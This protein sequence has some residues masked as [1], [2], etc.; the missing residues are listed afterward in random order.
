M[1]FLW[2]LG[3]LLLVIQSASV[4]ALIQGKLRLGWTLSIVLGQLT[5]WLLKLLFSELLSLFGAFKAI[6]LV[7]LDF[8]LAVIFVLLAARVINSLS[9]P[10]IPKLS[11]FD[12]VILAALI[13]SI[14]IQLLNV[15]LLAQVNW[16]SHTYHLP[17][18]AMW[19]QQGSLE[20]FPTPNGRE[21]VSQ[22]LPSVLYAFSL[23]YSPLGVA[24]AINSFISLLL[25]VLAV[26]SLVLAITGSQSSALFATLFVAS[27]PMV[28]VQAATTQTDLLASSSIALLIAVMAKV[29]T[30]KKRLLDFTSQL[31]IGVSVAFAIAAKATAV[32]ALVPLLI[33]IPLFLKLEKIPKTVLGGAGLA[34]AITLLTSGPYFFR[35][36]SS[37]ELSEAGTQVLSTDYSLNSILSGIAKNGATAL[38]APNENWTGTVFDA[39]TSLS[40]LLNLDLNA[41]GTNFMPTIPFELVPASSDSDMGFP[42]HILLAG[43]LLM[44]G[45]FRFNGN[46]SALLL[47]FGG[48][49][50]LLLLSITIKW[51]PWIGRF[52]FQSSYLMAAGLA[53]ISTVPKT[54]LRLSAVGLASVLVIASAWPPHRSIFPSP[55][56]SITNAS[57]SWND[58]S[59]AK[60]LVLQMGAQGFEEQIISIRR[61]LETIDLENYDQVFLETNL[62]SPKFFVS[63]LLSESGFKG[64]VTNVEIETEPLNPGTLIINLLPCPNQNEEVEKTGNS[65]YPNGSLKIFACRAP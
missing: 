56:V 16:D 61:S 64:K 48:F 44:F 6:N 60:D 39:T 43:V 27:V 30:D 59:T 23:S 19:L 40:L 11:K 7:V 25:I 8:S 9:W 54:V 57:I 10:E 28:A 36:L 51:Q 2:I 15:I 12:L 17:R 42:I 62:D 18:A 31:A 14:S 58:P 20:F 65:K 52:Q 34:G 33:L 35:L 50:Q 26:R 41:Q 38:Q 13:V 1:E 63:A 32:I 5:I 46:K 4:A 55:N 47:I 24:V 3:I 22:V 45:L 49:F 21:N 53:S 29:K 37:W